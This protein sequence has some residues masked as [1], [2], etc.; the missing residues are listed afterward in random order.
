[1]FQQFCL[2]LSGF[3]VSYLRYLMCNNHTEFHKTLLL[4][5]VP[6]AVF[7]R[8]DRSDD[9]TLS[10]PAPH[11]CYMTGNCKVTSVPPSN[12]AVI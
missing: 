3:T 11:F 2:P 9:L 5:V 12:T 4:M 10:C 1:M 6:M 7:E 8:R